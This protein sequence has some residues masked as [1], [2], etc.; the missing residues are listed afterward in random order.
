[1]RNNLDVFHAGVNALAHFNTFGCHEGRDPERVLR[2]LGLSRGQHG[3]GGG[4]RQSARP[5]SPV[6][7][8]AKGAIRRRGFDTTL[9][10]IHNPDVAAAGIDPLEHFLQFGLAEG[11]AAYAAIGH[12]RRTA[13]TRSSTCSTIRTSRRPASI[14]S[15]HYNA[16]RL[17]RGAQSERAGSTPP[18]ISRTT[19]TSRPPASIRCSTTSSS[20]GRKAAIRRPASTRSAISRPIRTSRRPA[21]TRSITS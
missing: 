12:G 7:L 9:Y 6:R 1:M 14:R 16:V 13:S 17:A 5:L 8:A 21:S 20:A 11:R 19:P 3:C 2:H 15:S 18:A 4:R 10:L